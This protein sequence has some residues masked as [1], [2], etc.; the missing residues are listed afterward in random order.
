[1]KQERFSY[2]ARRRNYHEYDKQSITNIS[3]NLSAGV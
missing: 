3:Y 2:T 1:M